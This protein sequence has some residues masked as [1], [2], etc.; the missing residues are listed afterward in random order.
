MDTHDSKRNK[1]TM[2]LQVYEK[3]KNE[4]NL[5]MSKPIIIG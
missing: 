3:T 5:K 1:L 2:I 4:R